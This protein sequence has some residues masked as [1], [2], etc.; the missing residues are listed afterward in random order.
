LKSFITSQNRETLFRIVHGKL[1]DVQY[2]LN[3]PKRKQASGAPRPIKNVQPSKAN[4]KV[5]HP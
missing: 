4:Y 1:F 3:K 5:E 2:G